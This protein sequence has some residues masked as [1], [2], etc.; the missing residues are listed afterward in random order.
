MRCKAW[1]GHCFCSVP[2]GSPEGQHLHRDCTLGGKNSMKDKGVLETVRM[3]VD[4]SYNVNA[5]L[6]LLILRLLV[7]LKK[8]SR[9][10]PTESLN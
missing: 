10:G 1:A 4:G 5:I 3:S 9:M 7:D 8:I 2:P 6:M